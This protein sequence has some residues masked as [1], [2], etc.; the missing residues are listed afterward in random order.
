LSERITAWLY[1]VAVER[2]EMPQLSWCILPTNAIALL[3]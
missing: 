2:G 3:D 1:R